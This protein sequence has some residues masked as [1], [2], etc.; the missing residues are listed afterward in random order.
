ML[1]YWFNQI[2]NNFYLLKY[3]LKVIFC[4]KKFKIQNFYFNLKKYYLDHINFTFN[5][6]QDLLI[7]LIVTTP[8]IEKFTIL[9]YRGYFKTWAFVRKRN[10][11]IKKLYKVSL[12]KINK[13]KIQLIFMG[14]CI[15]FFIFILKLISGL[16]NNL[17]IVLSLVGFLWI[18]IF[19]VIHLTISYKLVTL[20]LYNFYK[21]NVYMI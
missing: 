15:I 12:L 1:Q 5:K 7:D 19:L 20:K 2:K 6:L 9:C 14:S 10:Y 13:N 3:K 21:K 8:W 11:Y 18:N 17:L 4:F 16:N